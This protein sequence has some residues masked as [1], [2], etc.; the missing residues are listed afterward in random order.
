[1]RE[2]ICGKI[3]N[4]KGIGSK[5]TEKGVVLCGRRHYCVGALHFA[6]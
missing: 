4:G 3:I 6:Q 2:E 1:M 5:Q